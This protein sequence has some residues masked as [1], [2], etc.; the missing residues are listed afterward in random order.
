MP[1]QPK[2]VEQAVH[3][4]R[5]RLGEVLSHV[6]LVDDPVIVGH[7]KDGQITLIVNLKLDLKY[8]NDDRQRAHL[9]LYLDC[10]ELEWSDNKWAFSRATYPDLSLPNQES[11]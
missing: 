4:T 2:T 6:P 7:T 1:L 3:E 9:Q 10:M 11:T 5:G 8:W